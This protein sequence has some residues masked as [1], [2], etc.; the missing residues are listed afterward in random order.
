MQ[1]AVRS[2]LSQYANFSG[3]ARRSEYWFFT[4]AVI[5]VSFVVGIIDFIIGNSILE[6]VLIVATIVP[7]LSVGARRL[8]DTDRS[9]W[10]QLIGIIPIIGW[11]VLIV[12][13]ATDSTPDNKYGPN[14]KGAD[15][16]APYGTPPAAA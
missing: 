2:V 6:W 10:L 15:G 12:F 11:I 4:L 7:S 9:G 13:F 5:I 8:H 14:P 3:R 1:E 16:L